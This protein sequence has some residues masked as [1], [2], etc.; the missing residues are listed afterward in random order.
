MFRL[1][2]A[3]AV[4]YRDDDTSARVFNPAHLYL[5]GLVAELEPRHSCVPDKFAPTPALRD[6]DVGAAGIAIP[7]VAT[8]RAARCGIAIPGG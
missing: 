7:T 3:E 1:L 6:G 5:V 2:A 8:L 4:A